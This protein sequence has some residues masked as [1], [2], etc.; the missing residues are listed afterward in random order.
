LQQEYFRST[1]TVKQCCGAEI[2]LS[3]GARAEITNSGSGY[4]SGSCYGSSIYNRIEK[5]F[6]EKK[7]WLLKKF[8]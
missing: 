4:S 3:P 5:Y 2:K 6:I 8:L 7:S 1:F